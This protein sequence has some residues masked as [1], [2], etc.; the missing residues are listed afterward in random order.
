MSYFPV[1]QVVFLLLLVGGGAV[2]YGDVQEVQQ[3]A[4][5][6]PAE[7]KC[8]EKRGEDAEDLRI[9]AEFIARCWRKWQTAGPSFA[10]CIKDKMEDEWDGAYYVLVAQGPIVGFDT[11]A[12]TFAKW[13]FGDLS[14]LIWNMYSR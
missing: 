11:R 2:R 9:E 8:V 6:T 5:G 13:R 7:L 12:Y 14:I 10:T 1:L 4:T 3:N